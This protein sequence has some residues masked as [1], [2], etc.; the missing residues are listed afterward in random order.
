MDIARADVQAMKP[1]AYPCGRRGS[2]A[3]D[4]PLPGL[5][6]RELLGLPPRELLGLPPR[7]WLGLPPRVLLG[8]SLRDVM[9]RG[10]A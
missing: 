5:P 2:A 3:Q 8:L 4:R 1:P 10:R 6:P 7:E 9:T